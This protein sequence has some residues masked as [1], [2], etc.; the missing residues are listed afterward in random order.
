MSAPGSGGRRCPG[1]TRQSDRRLPAGASSPTPEHLLVLHPGLPSTAQGTPAAHGVMPTSFACT[2][3]MHSACSAYAL[4]R[5]VIHG[6]ERL[7]LCT[8]LGCQIA[9]H[10]RL[11]E[12][13][14][15][16]VVPSLRQPAQCRVA[17]QVQ[18]GRVPQEHGL[19]SAVQWLISW[20]LSPPL[21]ARTCRQAELVP[22]LLRNNSGSTW[23]QMAYW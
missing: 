4:Q 5:Q 23:Q 3:K 8:I 13:T 9:E 21:Q 2:F 14:H 20:Q 11:A 1:R 15:W 12:K 19:N 17:R 22:I 10:C 7:Q 16:R 6:L 18:V